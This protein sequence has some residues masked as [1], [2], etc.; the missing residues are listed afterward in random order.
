MDFKTIGILLSFLVIVA[1]LLS[2][3][4]VG[5]WACSAIYEKR[6]PKIARVR[7]RANVQRH[8]KEKTH[9]GKEE[10]PAEIPD[11]DS[12]QGI[13]KSRLKDTQSFV[14]FLCDSEGE[15]SAAQIEAARK[16]QDEKYTAKKRK[17]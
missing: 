13:L 5:L 4:Y 11:D 16:T 12:S 1:G 2:G 6:G 9:A 8:R 14:G 7:K 17:Q 15:D 3:G 10:N